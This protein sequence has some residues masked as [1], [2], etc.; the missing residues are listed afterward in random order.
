MAK[1]Q[2]SEAET[3]GIGH[4]SGE[5]SGARIKAFVERIERLEDAK[6]LTAADIKDVYAEAK[7]VGF[8][9]KIIRKIV[10]LRKKSKEAIREEQELL[11]LY[12]S[13]CQF[14]LGF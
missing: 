12:A 11:E 9:P 5:V 14:D 1:T 10:S 7:G 13:A 8:V 6:S 2:K 4:N 3:A